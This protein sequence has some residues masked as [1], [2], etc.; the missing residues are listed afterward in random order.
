MRRNIF[1]NLPNKNLEKRK[2][3]FLSQ[4][5]SISRDFTIYIDDDTESNEI[6]KSIKSLKIDML[7]SINIF[8]IYKDPQDTLN[9]KSVAFSV[10]VQP[11][12]KTLIDQ[13]IEDIS[14]KIIKVLKQNLNAD[15]RDS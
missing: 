10:K 5:Q 1:D 2:P 8:D 7:E 14:N 6:I 3:M 4:L 15:L 11:K 9:R 12:L 13:E